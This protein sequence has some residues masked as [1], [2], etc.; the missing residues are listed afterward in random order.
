MRP[1]WLTFL[2]VSVALVVGSLVIG[3][4][5]AAGIGVVAIGLSAWFAITNAS[6]SDPPYAGDR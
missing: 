4:V 1:L 6:G 2:A 5:L 3:N